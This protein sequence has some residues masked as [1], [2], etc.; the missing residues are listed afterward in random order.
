MKSYLYLPRMF[1]DKEIKLYSKINNKVHLNNITFN[2]SPHRKLNLFLITYF[3][4]NT[5]QQR[6]PYLLDEF[7]KNNR[8]KVLFHSARGRQRS[9]MLY[10]QVFYDRHALSFN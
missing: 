2:I 1:L 8:K 3:M 4:N 7:A 9:L 10:S 6:A 5:S